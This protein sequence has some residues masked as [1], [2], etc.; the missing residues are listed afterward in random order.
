MFLTSASRLVHIAVLSL[1]RTRLQNGVREN[2]QCFTGN[3]GVFIQILAINSRD[4][5]ASAAFH[6]L[7]IVIA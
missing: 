4:P 6:V 7:G 2:S 5:A 3:A 1:R